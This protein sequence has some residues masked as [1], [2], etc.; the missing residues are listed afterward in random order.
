LKRKKKIDL[1]LV[2][3]K[4]VGKLNVEDNFKLGNWKPRY[5][6]LQDR[7]ERVEIIYN[8]DYENIIGNSANKENLADGEFNV[9][10]KS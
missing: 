7:E 10:S 5:I 4:Y 2:K 8:V 6:I 1:C 9:I 3:G